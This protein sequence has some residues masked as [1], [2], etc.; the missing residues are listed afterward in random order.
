MSAVE[1]ARVVV[2]REEFRPE[3][4]RG[5]APR[6]AL[7]HAAAGEQAF[8]RGNLVRRRVQRSEKSPVPG[9]QQP[10]PCLLVE[11]VLRRFARGCEHELRYAAALNGRRADQFCLVR[12]C[13]ADRKA[14]RF[15]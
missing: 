1:R 10:E 15:R 11:H 9:G 14:L 8:Q 7:K 5:H 12:G 2:R 3:Q 4:R 13:D 6:S